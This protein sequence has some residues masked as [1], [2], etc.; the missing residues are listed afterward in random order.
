M[1]RTKGGKKSTPN[2]VGRQ[3]AF[4]EMPSDKKKGCTRPGS[5]NR[6]KQG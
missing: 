4:D 1:S 5:T 3:K 2:I 6:H